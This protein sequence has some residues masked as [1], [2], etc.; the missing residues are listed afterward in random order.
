MSST[1]HLMCLSHEPAL[2]I[3]NVSWSCRG[4][5]EFAGAITPE[6]SK[7]DLLIGRWSGGLAEIG[8]PPSSYH[9]NVIIWADARWLRLLAAAYKQPV[10]KRDP[11]LSAAMVRVSTCW[12]P[13]RMERL[14]AELEVSA[15]SESIRAETRS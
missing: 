10:R 8:C 1:Y 11:A 7:C 5:D 12:N 3:D 9:P 14:R 6:H 2:V 13:R 15:P 4:P